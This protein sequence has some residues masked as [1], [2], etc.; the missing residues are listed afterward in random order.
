MFHLYGEAARCKA[1]P[2][3]FQNVLFSMHKGK[4]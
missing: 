1:M 2:S 4:Y 3:L